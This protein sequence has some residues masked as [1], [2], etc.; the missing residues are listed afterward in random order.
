MR[1][2][3]KNRASVLAIAALLA[4][5]L[6]FWVFRGTDRGIAD[7][8]TLEI[9]LVGRGDLNTLDPARAATEAP[10][11][12]IWNVYD[13]LVQLGSD[14]K[15]EPSLAETWLHSDDLREWRFRLRAGAHFCGEGARAGSPVTPAD[16][17]YSIER[18]VRI[19][20]YSRSL[21]QDVLLGVDE[22]L[23]GG[24]ANISGIKLEGREVVF[25]LKKPF[26]FFPHRL[27]TSFMSVVPDGTTDD[28]PPPLGTG[29]FRIS[30]WDR[31]QNRV[32]LTKNDEHWQFSSSEVPSTLTIRTLENEGL[33]ASELKTGHLDWLEGTSTLRN[34]ILHLQNEMSHLEFRSFE[35][36]ELRLVPFNLKEPPFNG[37]HSV[38]LRRALNLGV[39]RARIVEALG[40]GDKL[41]GPI[42]VGVFRTLGLHYDPQQAKGILEKLPETAK[43]L[44]MIVE[45]VDEAQFIAQ[46]LVE[47]WREI[48]L[49]V[50]ALP[51]RANF[52]DRMVRGDYQMALAYYGPFVPSPEQYVWVYRRDAVP[53]PNV[54]AYMDT[55]FEKAFQSFI[56][57]PDEEFRDAAGTSMVNAL[58]ENPPVVWLVKPP[59]FVATTSRLRAP[60]S[61]GL[62]SFSRLSRVSDLK[63]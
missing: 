53:I 46:L 42:P 57:S 1:S 6:L 38:S 59:R 30:H 40:G 27:A 7:S 54:M 63:D 9:G 55:N 37:E 39:D 62:P 32:V 49:E 4:V 28:G 12:V 16:V 50:T 24:A 60:R 41:A 8:S 35:H 18:A 20:G 34:A 43:H 51:G 14:G 23:E 25:A 47:Q 5:I 56:T 22:F 11:L 61:G 19:P 21:V 36:T 52:F 45:P 10:T 2:E 31:L 29:L 3:E 48:G 26:A 33:A 17:K 44:E 58:L 15:L 13:R